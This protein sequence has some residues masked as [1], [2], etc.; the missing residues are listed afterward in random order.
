MTPQQAVPK[1]A[2]DKKVK[3]KKKKSKKAFENPV[4]EVRG[5]LH[6]PATAASVLWDAFVKGMRT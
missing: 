4:L 5:S 2:S 6:S 3:A 1:T